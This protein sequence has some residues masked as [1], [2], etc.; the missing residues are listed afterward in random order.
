MYDDT[1]EWH[2]VAEHGSITR[3]MV[4]YGSSTKDQTK[5][6]AVREVA[7][8]CTSHQIAPPDKGAK[9]EILMR[10][11]YG[12]KDTDGSRLDG[13]HRGGSYPISENDFSVSLKITYGNFSYALCGDL[14]GRKY[15]DPNGY[16]YHDIES[17]VAPMMG[18]VDLY[19]AN[20]HALETSTN[21]NWVDELKPSVTV[22]SCRTG[23]P[24]DKAMDRLVDVGGIIYATNDCWSYWGYDNYHPDETRIFYDDII[25]TVPTGSDTFTV[26]RKD[27]SDAETYEIRKNKTPGECKVLA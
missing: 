22:I 15:E 21:Q 23:P 25:V 17:S 24:Y 4:C 5:L 11:A 26:S 27:G 20:H 1:I 14:S 13:D 3:R 6:S 12:V 19:H 18:E 16:T 7:E 10:D 9:I 2:N 8:L